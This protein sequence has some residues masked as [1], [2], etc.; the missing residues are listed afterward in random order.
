[1]SP[2]R[3]LSSLG[4]SRTSVDMSTVVDLL[5]ATVACLVCITVDISDM[6]TVDISS[7]AT[8]AMSGML[9]GKAGP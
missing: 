9:V 3:V 1:M 4:D 5:V 6:T 8:V 2:A 7:L